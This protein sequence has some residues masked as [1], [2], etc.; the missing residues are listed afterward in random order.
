[1]SPVL[2]TPLKE[3]RVLICVGAGGVG[4]TTVSAALALQGAAAGRSSLV[5]SRHSNVQ[6]PMQSGARSLVVPGPAKR[7]IE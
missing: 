1:M 4:K 3:K 5:S 6:V 2:T 7:S